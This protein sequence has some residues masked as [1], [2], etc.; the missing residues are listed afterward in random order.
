MMQS[1]RGRSVHGRARASGV[2]TGIGINVPTALHGDYFEH[3]RAS[4]WDHYLSNDGRA[5][6]EDYRSTDTSDFATALGAKATR[7]G[8]TTGSVSIAKRAEL[9]MLDTDRV[10][11]GVGGGGPADRVV[12]LATTSDINSVW[13]AGKPQNG[14]AECLMS[15]GPV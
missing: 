1:Y 4:L 8:D 15:I 6:V 10:G 9:V 3:I 11:F 5:I 14:M 2:A 7:L 12:T 13:I